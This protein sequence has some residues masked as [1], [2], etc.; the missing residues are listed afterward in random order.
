MAGPIAQQAARFCRPCL[1]T[2][3]WPADS[4]VTLFVVVSRCIAGAF[5]FCDAPQE[6]FIPGNLGFDPLNL[7]PLDDSAKFANMR[8]KELNNGR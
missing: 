6:D 4:H 3:A 7:A 5:F 8:L 1:A 2:V